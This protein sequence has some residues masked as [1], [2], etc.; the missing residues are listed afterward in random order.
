MKF[1]IHAHIWGKVLV[2][3]CLLNAWWLHYAW[4][5][6]V[7]SRVLL[8]ENLLWVNEDLISLL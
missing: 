3:L 7:S 6:T 5:S 4:H 2:L 1:Q 8:V